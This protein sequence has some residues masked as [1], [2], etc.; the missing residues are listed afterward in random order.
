M[1]ELG[2]SGE[3]GAV[4]LL[5]AELARV[6]LAKHLTSAEPISPWLE[7]QGVSCPTSCSTRGHSNLSGPPTLGV[8]LIHFMA[9]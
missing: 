2:S 3:M 5:P 9:S 7:S 6:Y 4:P 8:H 1:K